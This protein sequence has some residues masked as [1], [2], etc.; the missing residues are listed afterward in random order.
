M[1]KFFKIVGGTIIAIFVLSVVVAMFTEED[2]PSTGTSS[3]SS[4]QKSSNKSEKGSKVIDAT[5][6]STEALGLKVALGEIIVS[7]DKIQ[8]GLNLE[9]VSSNALT[10]YPD[11]GSAVVGN[12]QLDAN[13]FFTDGDVSG[14]IHS[15]VLKEGVIEFLAP[16]GK[17]IDVDSLTQIKLAFGDVFDD[18]DFDSK[19]VSF[20]VSVQ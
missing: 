13:L 15:G 19:D 2:K 17:S 6:Y 3:S 10:F 8:V 7:K 16:D 5:G 20:S 4:E 11:Q 18:T 9:N 12:L 1:K 14:E